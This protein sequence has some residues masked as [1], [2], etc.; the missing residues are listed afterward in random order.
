MNNNLERFDKVVSFINR[1]GIEG[2]VSWLKNETDFFTAPASTK[3]H[4]NYDGGLLEHSL[5]TVEFS[6][7]LYNYIVKRKPEY[8]YLKESVILCA[9]F[10]DVCKVNLYSKGEKY[11][12]DKNNRWQTY[13]TYEI[14]DTFPL[15]HGSKSVYLINRW[16]TLKNE[17]ALAIEH[18]MGLSCVAFQG[19][20]KFAYEKA[21]EHP[22]VKIIQ[23]ADMA[24][25]SVED[26][27]DYKNLNN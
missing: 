7:H 20:N 15:N 1:D 25:G 27:I 3:F 24:S 19:I 11:F 12:K 14:N 17:E 18:H 5:N 21:I 4:C 26:I 16:I 13:L 8:E 2:L 10:H 22:L 6:L 23:S 9:L